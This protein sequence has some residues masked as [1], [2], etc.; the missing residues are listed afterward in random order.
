MSGSIKKVDSAHTVPCTYRGACV[1]CPKADFN[2][3]LCEACGWN[4][5]VEAKRKGRLVANG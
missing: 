2:S 1:E 4:P 3:N 5:E